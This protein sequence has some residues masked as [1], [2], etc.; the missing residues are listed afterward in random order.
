MDMNWRNRPPL[1]GD[2][3]TEE[4]YIEMSDAFYDAMETDGEERRLRNDEY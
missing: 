3:E 4:E 2:Y 1:R